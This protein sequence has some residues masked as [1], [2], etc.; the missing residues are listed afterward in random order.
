MRFTTW[1]T[2]A[3]TLFISTV[4]L[5]SLIPAANAIVDLTFVHPKLGDVHHAGETISFAWYVPK[6][7]TE[8]EAMMGF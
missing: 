2:L 6:R 4:A 5:L 1:S 7:E 8:R 3:N